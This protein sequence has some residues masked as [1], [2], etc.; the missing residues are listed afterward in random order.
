MFSGG[1]VKT[2]KTKFAMLKTKTPTNFYLRIC[3]PLPMAVKN[4][5]KW[6]NADFHRNFYNLHAHNQNNYYMNYVITLNLFF[7]DIKLQTHKVPRVM[8]TRIL[9]R[10][11]QF[12]PQEP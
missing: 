9:V 6:R 12:Y 10:L 11:I 3:L 8:S 1:P 5:G 4:I 7:V 2:Q